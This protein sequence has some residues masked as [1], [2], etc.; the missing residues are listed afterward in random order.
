[1]CAAL[2]LALFAFAMRYWFL[3]SYPYP[4]MLHEQDGTAYIY[5]ARDILAFKAPENIFMPPFYPVV[6]ALFSL[7]P[8]KFELAARVASITMDALVVLPL[9]GLSRIVLPRVATVVVC[10]LWATFA[11]CLIFAPSPLSQS[12]YLCM[13]LSGIYLLYRAITA[14]R[15][16][17][18]FLLA[19][20]CFACAY[21]T[22]PEG[23]VA[24]GAG[25]VLI[26]L[27]MLQ[28]KDSRRLYGQGMLLFLLG[29]ALFA[30]PFVLLLHARLGHWTFTAKTTVA[31]K[32]IDGALTLGKGNAAA[33][34]GLA[35]WLEQFGGV[36]GGLRFIWANM[37]GF[38]AI[39][40]RS[41]KP[42][43]HWFALLGLP[44]LFIGKHF[45][46]RLFLLLP[47]LVVIPVCIANLPKN[48]SY[49][50]PLFPLYLLAFV[51]G[52][53]QL[54]SLVRA[55]IEKM[56]ITLPPKLAATVFYGLLVVPAGLVATDS[57]HVAVANYTADEIVYQAELSK[58]IFQGAAADLQRISQQQDIVMTRWGLITYFADRPLVS[59]PKGNIDEVVAHGRQNK[60]SY[61]VID[62]ESVLTRRQ[63][64][65]EL[66]NPLNGGAIDPRFGLQVVAT[67]GFGD[68][69][70]YVIYRYLP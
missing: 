12:T 46:R 22:R 7:L 56:P 70:G 42:W 33:K 66:L 5:I 63:E 3:Y 17:W 38:L 20:A 67:R 4:L 41:F 54:I 53:W 37:Q 26:S 15:Q 19:G 2:G 9:Y 32:G 62:T 16:G 39:L 65:T 1:M 18:Q 35:L 51:T 29:F 28:Q 58:R 13:L 36:S 60:V 6:I 40:A 8:I 48:H 30:L 34:D 21:L 64:L 61:L 24:V 10:G 14:E 50:Y 44:L 23:L 45:N 31:I 55:G 49:I 47:I 52:L 59:L 69:G 11:F 27:A 68:L 25:V 57:Y 43:M